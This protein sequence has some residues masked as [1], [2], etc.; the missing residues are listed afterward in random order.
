[1]QK[2]KLFNTR[3]I[4]LA[5]LFVAI[6]VILKVVLSFEVSTWLRISFVQT[7]MILSGIVL[8][9]VWGFI[10]GFLGD[11]LGYIAKPAGGAYLPQFG[12]VAGLVGFIPGLFRKYVFKERINLAIIVSVFLSM[13]LSNGI[14][15]SYFISLLSSSNTFWGWVISRLPAQAVMTVVHSVICIL[16]VRYGKSVLFKDRPLG[17]TKIKEKEPVSAE[18]EAQ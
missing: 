16:I 11:F 4:V 8:G 6:S 3:D 13:F 7:P 15:R 1:M 2:K 14:L 17:R 9:P 10:V 12:L 18:A 5:S